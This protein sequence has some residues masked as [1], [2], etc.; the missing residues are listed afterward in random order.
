MKILI[1]TPL[2]P[3]DTGDPSTYVKELSERLAPDHSVTVLLYGHLPEAVPGVTLRAVDKRAPLLNRLTAF[4][5]SLLK[6]VRGVDVVLINNGPSTELPFLL[7][8]PFVRTKSILIESDPLATTAAT[9]GIYSR[10]HTYLTA[11]VTSGISF[12]DHETYRRAEWLPFGTINTTRDEA[13]TQWWSDHLK[14]ILAV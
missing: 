4:T 11:R 2:F 8:S 7:V 10:V 6:E 14:T 3:P 1:L 5:F 13:R 12:P 9:T